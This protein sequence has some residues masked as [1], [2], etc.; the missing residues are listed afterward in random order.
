MANCEHIKQLLYLFKVIHHKYNIYL[1][2]PTHP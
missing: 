2:L 1:A